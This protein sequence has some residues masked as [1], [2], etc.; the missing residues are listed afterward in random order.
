MDQERRPAGL[1]EIAFAVGF[2]GLIGVLYILAG[3]AAWE[4][5]HALTTLGAVSLRG[6]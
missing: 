1:P 4:A 2:V 6:R 5:W 3:L